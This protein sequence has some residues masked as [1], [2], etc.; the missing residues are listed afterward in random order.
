MDD[1]PGGSSSS[2][3]VLHSSSATWSEVLAPPALESM[4]VDANP[5]E[6]SALVEGDGFGSGSMTTQLDEVPTSTS[7][8]EDEDTELDAI[9]G[10]LEAFTMLPLEIRRAI[11][12][13]EALPDPQTCHASSKRQ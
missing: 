2:T 8:A 11:I 6:V 7:I 10:C 1:T 9:S 3:A 5:L 4:E 12:G 13:E